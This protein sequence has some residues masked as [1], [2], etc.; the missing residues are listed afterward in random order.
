MSLIQEAAAAYT[1][2]VR[3]VV[4]V[5][6]EDESLRAAI[7]SLEVEGFSRLDISV[8]GRKEEIKKTYGTSYRDPR[9][10]EDDPNAPRGV[11]I[12]PEEQRLAEVSLVGGGVLVALV[13]APPLL[14][15]PDSVSGNVPVI[16][17]LSAIGGVIGYGL[18]CW[19]R[20]Y[21]TQRYKR[22]LREGG[23][24]LWVSAP[25]RERERK[26]KRALSRH[27]ARNIHIHEIK[28]TVD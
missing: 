2:S 25:T 18:A 12:M 7:D 24:L 6:T 5:F 15:T 16:L 10:M 9:E 17:T 13:V 3:E 4:G 8:L 19:L 23:L 28:R 1:V 21:R 11:Y 27:G 26:A 20:Y 22:Q 14:G